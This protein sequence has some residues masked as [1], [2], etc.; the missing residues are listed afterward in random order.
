MYVPGPLPARQL[1]FEPSYAHSEAN[2]PSQLFN[3][4]PAGRSGNSGTGLNNGEGF[5]DGCQLTGIT[6]G[7]D[8]VLANLGAFEGKT[9]LVWLALTENRIDNICR[10][11]DCGRDLTNIEVQHKEGCR[12]PKVS[13]ISSAPWTQTANT[14]VQRD[15]TIPPRLHHR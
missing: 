7:D 4:S 2:N 1:P 8:K 9:T 5:G 11:C 14:S 15:A 13:S 3:G 6:L 12:W 10:H